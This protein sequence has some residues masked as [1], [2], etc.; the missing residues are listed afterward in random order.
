ML[1][2]PLTMNEVVY[3]ISNIIILHIIIIIVLHCNI[4]P[5][6]WF[7]YHHQAFATIKYYWRICVV[8]GT[9]IFRNV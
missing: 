5:L 9:S 2:T 3:I 7:W 4:T 6:D 1:S 8:M